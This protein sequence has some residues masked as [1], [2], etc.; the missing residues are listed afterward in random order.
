MELEPSDYYLL[1]QAIFGAMGVTQ[2]MGHKSSAGLYDYIP[3]PVEDSWHFQVVF[4]YLTMGRDP[5]HRERFETFWI[6]SHLGNILVNRLGD[7]S[8]KVFADE[9]AIPLAPHRSVS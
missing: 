6:E 3:P 4:D 8:D 1:G 2:A 5:E 7:L 9:S